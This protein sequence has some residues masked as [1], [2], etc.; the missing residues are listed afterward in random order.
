MRLGLHEFDR[1]LRAKCD[2]NCSIILN[3]SRY[4]LDGWPVT[5]AQVDLL[6]K[7]RI[8]PVCIVQLEV[9]EQ[10]MLRRGEIDRA[11]LSR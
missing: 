6:T 5:K 9:S 1:V 2:C 10:E 11:S 8:V 7:F 4:I 3:I